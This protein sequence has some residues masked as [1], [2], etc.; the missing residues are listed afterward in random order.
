MLSSKWHQLWF[1]SDTKLKT[2]MSW[3]RL[4][5][6]FLL[7]NCVAIRV[8]I[9]LG[10]KVRTSTITGVWRL[11][12][13]RWYFFPPNDCIKSVKEALFVFFA[14]IIWRT[15]STKLFRH[16]VW[17]EPGIPGILFLTCY[18]HSAHVLLSCLPSEQLPFVFQNFP[19][20]CLDT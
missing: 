10:K 4:D 5:S 17:G 11:F 14:D 3:T 1:P 7:W 20:N 16:K 15:C 8:S 2:T 6:F 18:F 9:R 12:N 13:L 19:V